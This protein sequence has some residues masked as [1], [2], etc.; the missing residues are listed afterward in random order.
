MVKT[1]G[2][3]LVFYSWVL[4]PSS[5]SHTCSSDEFP[6]TSGRCIPR[7]WYCDEEGDCPDGSD[8]PATCGKRA[9]KH[10]KHYDVARETLPLLPNTD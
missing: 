1:D 3:K 9:S 10:D 5:A 6:C 4:P 7:H 2:N 8:E